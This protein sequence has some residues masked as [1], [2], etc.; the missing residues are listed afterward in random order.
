MVNTNIRY[1]WHG[2][3]MMSVIP[4]LEHVILSDLDEAQGLQDPQARGRSGCSG[5]FFADNVGLR[6]PVNGSWPSR[7]RT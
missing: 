3:G 5:I 4:I 1:L 2:T 6:H 7:M